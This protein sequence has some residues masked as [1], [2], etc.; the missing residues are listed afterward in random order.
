MTAL[1]ETLGSYVPLLIRRRLAADP[2]PLHAPALENFPAAVMLADISG[3]TALA[4]R[5]AQHGE[6]GSEE[7]SRLLNIFF[8]QLINI[9]S[10]HGGD[11]LKFAGD[12]ML[13]AW[14][15]DEEAVA[16]QGA[17]LQLAVRRAAQCALAI[18][19]QA[20]TEV[21]GLRLSLRVGIGVGEILAAQLGGERNRWELV[22][23]GEPL[24]Q[25]ST[26]KRQAEPGEVILSPEAWALYTTEAV[27]IDDLSAG[28]KLATPLNPP[29][30]LRAALPAHLSPSAE[31]ALR[32]YIPA[33]I[34]N[35]LAAGQGGAKGESDW[36][37][38]LRRVTV[39]F[40]NLP[41]LDHNVPLEQAQA[42]MQAM[43]ETLYYF[44]GSINKLS[45]DDKG[46]TLLAAFGLPPL[47]HEDDASRGVQAAL[48][49]RQ[50]LGRLGFGDSALG[51]ATGRVFCGAIGNDARREY[52]LIGDV[53][54]LAARLMELS[55]G[56]L[57]CDLATYQAARASV[58]FETL[59]PASVKGKAE[60]VLTFRPL[61]TTATVVVPRDPTQ[62]IGRKPERDL[63]LARVQAL[64]GGESSVVLIEGE[65]GIGKSRL[66]SDLLA[67]AKERGIV[68][69][70]GGGD[71]IEKTNPY[72]AWR[73]VFNGIF[74]LTASADTNTQREHV[75]A[76]LES[77]AEA[78]ALAPLLNTFLP[79]DLI[80]NE[81]T[82]AMTGQVRA[83]NLRNLLIK[84]L[85]RE[86]NNLPLL[87]A[88]E[89]AHWLDSASWTLALTALQNIQPLL[90][91]V[92]TR[93]LTDPFPPEYTQLLYAPRLHRLALQA[94]STNDTAALVCQR[95][96]VKSLPDS[97]LDLIRDKA[98]GHPFFSEELGY[99]LRDSGVLVIEGEH[100]RLAHNIQL[101]SINFP[102][103]VQGAII[104]RIDRLAPPLQFALKTASVIGRVFAYRVL[105]DIHPIE[106][107]KP[108]LNDYLY[109]LAYLD[110]TPLESDEPELAYIFKH[111]ITHEVAYNL[112]LF[113]QRQ[114]LHRAVAEWHEHTYTD[115]LS[116]FYSL[117][118]HH[119]S[120]AIGLE[121]PDPF[122]L[123]KALEYLG[124]AGEQA[125]MGFANRE[126]VEFFNE[127]IRF[128]NR[129]QNPFSVQRRA[130]WERMLGEAYFRLGELTESKTHTQQALALHNTP[131][132][133]SRTR[134]ALSLA[135]E[136]ARQ[137]VHRALP[138]KPAPSTDANATLEQ[139]R[140]LERLGEIAYYASDVV[141]GLYAAVRGL[142]LA[143]GVGPSPELARA[144]ANMCVAANV[145]G[146]HPLADEYAA[147]AQ[148]TAETVNDLAA[149]MT[150]LNTTSVHTISTGQWARAQPALER[151]CEIADR[152]GDRRIYEGSR[153]GLAH[154]AHH[155][156]EFA[157][158]A[159]FW[160]EL[161]ASARKHNNDQTLGWGLLGQAE[162]VLR[163]GGEGHG[164]AARD[165]VQSALPL[166]TKTAERAEEARALGSLALAYTR[167]NQPDLARETVER[168]V[169]LMRQFQ[170]A[171][172]GVFGGY[173]SIAEAALTLAEA[174]EANRPALL[175]LS[176]E[177]CIALERF[178]KSFPIGRPRA[179]LWQGLDA[180]LRNDPALA[181]RHWQRALTAA[182][183]LNMSY[184]IAL[185]EYQ[186]GRH[187][188]GTQRLAR[189]TR[190]R[191]LFEE[192]G[193]S[194]DEARA[195]NLIE[196]Q[197]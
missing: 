141:N 42:L 31:V 106:S 191:S 104:S 108:Q 36:L 43:Q 136:L 192:C 3:F 120:R 194:W 4:E 87:L 184:E 122:V 13:A 54:N 57:L 124:R 169:G 86:A 23:A 157:Q 160:R 174:S 139:V 197:V 155:R 178:A 132:P 58:S 30:P 126:A 159:S 16:L 63:L 117:V 186:I 53:V 164:D 17:A 195:H 60:P 64:Q 21:E 29:L 39:L 152:L 143:E 111:V 100:G 94:L 37:A 67:Q 81:L 161:T 165:L 45:V 162:A 8:G 50:T 116:P 183:K 19:T 172:F 68:T 193:A 134:T 7:L 33:A 175:I 149:I 130:R 74:D 92:A 14:P 78:L 84:V 185:A 147:R 196:R 88:I 93:P 59:E 142:N 127:A 166:L 115:D 103:T 49:I 25:M 56:G 109:T 5:L 77:D 150:V 80:D 69:L 48:R 151:S 97:V 26:A 168:A 170:L 76:K 38:E 133:G 110:I 154:I 18:Q 112:L 137:A 173:F 55:K 156:G 12:A 176:H 102:D 24:V 22:P 71:A 46:V 119:W 35:R 107:D 145:V 66:I 27:A 128:A 148:A 70:L 125:L 1:L 62:M 182:E 179:L 181:N 163:L 129:T 96:G 89:D 98:E 91:V 138:I 15:A 41:R 82:E 20:L 47:A 101:E 52:T 44:E 158:S 121:N 51:V 61:A 180:R 72:H 32:A 95:L 2:T 146:F 40:V 189:L 65:A 153:A 79:L 73:D 177:A 11:V 10:A 34:V 9:I 123:A 171:S 113:A 167:L 131:I 140:A 6:S 188:T 28:V 90:L 83:E 144:Y 190:A 118:A 75:L 187:A 85:K 114:Q 99:A 105:R 135:G